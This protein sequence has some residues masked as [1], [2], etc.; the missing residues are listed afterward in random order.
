MYIA[1]RQSRG[2]NFDVNRKVL[3]L[4]PFAA[5]FK[6]LKSDFIHSFLDLMHAYSPG[7]GGHTVP[8]GQKF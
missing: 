3:S 2:R 7:T 5:S 8:R 4:Y 6:P 1:P